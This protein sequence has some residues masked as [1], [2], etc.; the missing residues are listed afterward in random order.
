LI[1]ATNRDLEAA[2]RDGSFRQDLYYRLNGVTVPRP[3]L[4]ER[5]EDIPLLAAYFVMFP[6]RSATARCAA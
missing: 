3:P 4:L 1:A 2:M 5:R 6:T